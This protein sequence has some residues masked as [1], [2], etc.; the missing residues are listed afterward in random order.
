MNNQE[1]LT[2]QSC[3]VKVHKANLQRISLGTVI[4]STDTV[5]NSNIF[6]LLFFFV[7]FFFF[8]FYSLVSFAFVCVCVFQKQKN[9]YFDTHLTIQAGK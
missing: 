1:K 7:F 5:Y 6:F 4:F 2:D 8:L 9:V 3:K